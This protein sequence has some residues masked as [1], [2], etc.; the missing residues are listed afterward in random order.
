MPDDDDAGGN[1]SERAP[2]FLIPP[3]YP[4][5]ISIDFNTLLNHGHIT[6][7][8][9]EHLTGL[10][11]ALQDSFRNATPRPVPPRTPAQQ[12]RPAAH[13]F[14]D[15]VDVDAAICPPMCIDN[16]E[17]ICPPMCIDNPTPICPPMCIDNPTPVCPPMCID[18]FG[19]CGT[20]EDRP[21][22]ECPSFI[23]VVVPPPGGECA[24]KVETQ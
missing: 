24:D 21:P 4:Q 12:P 9:L 1:S 7:E 17:P 22:P 16:P 18:D 5:V 15:G 11:G 6:P 8:V 13:L 2:G 20:F 19:S 23:N 10:L 14:E 3:G